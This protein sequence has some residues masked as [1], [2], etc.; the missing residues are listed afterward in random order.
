M[1]ILKRIG[2]RA[3]QLAFRAALPLL[4][5]REPRVLA[6]CEA[7]SEVIA[8]HGPR[9]ALIVTSAG[10]GR[11][12]LLAPVEEALR[13]GGVAYAIYD[14]TPPDPTVRDVEEALAL[15]REKACD[16]L[17]AIGGGSVIDCAKGV[18]ARVAYPRRP[19]GSLAGVMR[20]NR[21]IPL[22]VAIP[23]TAGTGSEAT[24]AAVITDS[25]LRHK[26]AI[27]SFPLIPRYAVLDPRLTCTLPP[28]LTATTGMD[29]LTHAVEAYIGRST[30]KRTRRL[31]LEATA[32]I[33]RS[34]QRAYTDGQDIDARADM[35][36]AAYSAGVAF[37]VSYV[38]YVHAI[39]HSIG[40]RY[41]VAHGLANAVIMP[42]VLEC[43]GKSAHKRLHA[44]AVAAGVSTADEP[45]KEGAMRFIEAVRRLNAAMNIPDAIP[46]IREA[47]VPLLARHAAKEANP[48][49]PV[50]RL[51]S[52][53]E[54]EG[55]Y[56]RIA[57]GAAEK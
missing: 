51:M 15:Y 57:V 3:L 40:G 1:F 18:G 54:M 22:L 5:Y 9:A 17:I 29:A 25:D 44:L 47:D 20:V 52:A 13:K 33:F 48:L 30:T 12:G 42:Y 10:S 37:S 14:R 38:G 49:Y 2:C 43:Y 24:L 35:L 41:G 23:T 21:R 6:S 32:L 4:P 36:R 11:R 56:R 45:Q 16:M 46:E 55:L 27:M 28:H 8:A 39:A 34:L 19:L 31:A 50:P 53:G 26:Y 7:L